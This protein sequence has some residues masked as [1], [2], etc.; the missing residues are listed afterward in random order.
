M[1]EPGMSEKLP[2]WAKKL[3]NV[4]LIAG[5]ITAVGTAGA[6]VRPWFEWL[7]TQDLRKRVA[8]NSLNIYSKTALIETRLGNIEKIL[9]TRDEGRD[10]ELLEM[11]FKVWNQKN[12]ELARTP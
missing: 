3:R 8:D 5:A 4:I 1:A 12:S 11:A 10:K 7:V 6:M 9:K 2:P